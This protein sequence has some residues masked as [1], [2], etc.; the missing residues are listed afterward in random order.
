V[1]DIVLSTLNAR[2]IHSAFGLRYLLANLGPLRER[3]RIEEFDIK[4]PAAEVADALLQ[5]DPRIVGLGVYIW[6]VAPLTQVVSLL[7]RSRPDLTVVLGGPEVSWE[8]EQQEICRQADY[9][10][11]GEADLEFARLCGHILDGAPPGRKVV[12]AAPPDLDRLALPYDRY[13]PADIAHRIV[14]VEA[15]RGCPF[16][17]EYCVSSQDVPVRFFPLPRLFDAFEDLLARGARAFKFVDRTFNLNIPFA[18]EILRFFLERR[19]PGLFL[20]FEMIPDRFP[21]ELRDAIQQFPAGSL[22]LEVGVQ[23]MNP[24]V[25]ARIRR[26]QDFD[27]LRDNL[28]F[29][30]ERTGALLHAD[31][32]AG[33]PGESLESFGAGLNELVR[34]RPQVIQI[35]LLKRLRGAPVT[36]HDREWAMAFNPEP[37]YEVVRNRLIGEEDLRRLGRFARYWERVVNRGDFEETVPLLWRDRGDAFGEFMRWSDWLYARLRRAHGIPLLT[38]AERLF[39]FLISVRGLEPGAVA[40]TLGRDYRRAGRRER[41]RFLRRHLPSASPAPLISGGRPG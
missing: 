22:H 5:I 2:Y 19:R 6:N 9:V 27:A 20:H 31:L 10:I 16:Q 11:A 3:A 8:I 18:L 12:H 38:L 34:L 32:I 33:L 7:K 39:E 28:R 13:G 17:C 29:L 14:Y 23:T 40:E 1:D 25:A 21:G 35:G 30:R 24:E 15:S 37:P 4:R 41:P 26:R 36:R